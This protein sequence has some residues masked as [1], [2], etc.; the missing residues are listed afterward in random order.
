MTRRTREWALAA[1][2]VLPAVI[3]MGVLIVYPAVKT[4][5]LSFFDEQGSWVGLK[6]FIALLQNEDTLNLSRF[7]NTYPPWGSLIHNAVW[8]IIHLPVTV[9]FGMVLVLSFF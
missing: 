9:I 4:L 7:P 2:F 6:N 5:L 3:L 1:S 8:I